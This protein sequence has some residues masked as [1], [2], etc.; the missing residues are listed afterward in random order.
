MIPNNP[1]IMLTNDDGVDAPG[2][3]C[4]EKIAEQLSNDVWIAAPA[5]EQSGASR[6]MSFADPIRVSELGPRRFS[7]HGTP[8]DACF[9]GLHDLIPDTKPGLVLSGVNRG[10][11]LADDVTVSGT[12]AAAIQAMKMGVPA[13]ALSQTLSGFFSST[14]VAF[15]T[16][17]AHAPRIIERLVSAGWPQDVVININFPPCPPDEVQGVQITRQGTRDHWHLKAE[18]REDLRKRTYYWLGFEGGL[19]NPDPGDDLHA[20]YNN[21]ISITPLRVD[22]THEPTMGAFANLFESTPTA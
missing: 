5:A 22:L 7:I 15:E 9:L 10:Q 1:R 13:I 21:H 8:S 14:S 16:A 20:I 3:A 4:L 19:S 12:V 17:L 2:L 11:N 6:K 18:R